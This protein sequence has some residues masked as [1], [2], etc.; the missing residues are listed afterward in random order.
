M[1]SPTGEP[2]AGNPPVRFGGRGGRE[3]QPFLPYGLGVGSSLHNACYV[4]PTPAGGG[5]GRGG[6]RGASDNKF[7]IRWRRRKTRDRTGQGGP[8]LARVLL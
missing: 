1:K 5:R 8:G 7:I 3:N 2:D 6:A 4:K